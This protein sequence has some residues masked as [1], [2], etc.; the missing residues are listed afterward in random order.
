MITIDKKYIEI[1]NNKNL[2]YIKIEEEEYSYEYFTRM[3]LSY[4]KE[5]LNKILFYGIKTAKD[6]KSQKDIFNSEGKKLASYTSENLGLVDVIE[7]NY[8]FSQ[9]IAEN[10]EI[11]RDIPD[12]LFKNSSQFRKMA[13]LVIKNHLM[14]KYSTST[15]VDKQKYEENLQRY[16]EYIEK[17]N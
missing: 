9:S 14:G 3:I 4:E 11:I 5:E 15:G 8:A 12:E 7:L 6:G 13:K 17:R 2:P 1:L 16:E 10:P